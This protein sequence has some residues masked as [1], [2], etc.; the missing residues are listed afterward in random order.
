MEGPSLF[1]LASSLWA[2]DSQRKRGDVFLRFVG[3]AFFGVKR[4]NSLDLRPSGS[5]SIS[6]CGAS[7]SGSLAFFHAAILC[8]YSSS[9]LFFGLRLGFGAPLRSG[10]G[11]EN[12]AGIPYG[13]SQ[14]E[15]Q[16]IRESGGVR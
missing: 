14:V 13:F 9:F 12:M 10:W 15:L 7:S 5:G 16:N 6:S 3:D 2:L 1:A 8:A 4:F 11:F